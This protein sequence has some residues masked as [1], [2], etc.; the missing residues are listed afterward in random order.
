MWAGEKLP[1]FAYIPQDAKVLSEGTR[2][3][4]I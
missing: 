2:P 4:F 3:K 1:A